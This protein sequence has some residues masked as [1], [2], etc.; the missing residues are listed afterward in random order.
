MV[1]GLPFQGSFVRLTKQRISGA[2]DVW[3]KSYDYHN[4]RYVSFHVEKMKHHRLRRSF[5]PESPGFP[6][7]SFGVEVVIAVIMARIY[8]CFYLCF[9]AP[10]RPAPLSVQLQTP[11]YPPPK[12]KT[13]YIFYGFRASGFQTFTD[14]QT[15]FLRVV[16]CFSH[17]FSVVFF[18]QE[19]GGSHFL[20]RLRIR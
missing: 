17:A 18:S 8:S 14:F 4:F 5:P 12:Y 2:G 11:R 7:L 15:H 13:I 6:C 20:A 16:F 10:A 1:Q 3:G 19:T 9:L